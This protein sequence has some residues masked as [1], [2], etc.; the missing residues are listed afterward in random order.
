[1][2]IEDI[3]LPVNTE[4]LIN[5]VPHPTTGEVYIKVQLFTARYLLW[6]NKDHTQR[7]FTPAAFNVLGLQAIVDELARDLPEIKDGN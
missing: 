7:I 3:K 1:M 4:L 5:I 2:K 6:H